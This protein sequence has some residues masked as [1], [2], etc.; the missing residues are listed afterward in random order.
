M[1]GGDLMGTV[2]LIGMMALRLAPTLRQEGAV[3]Q[4]RIL[5]A[6]GHRDGDCWGKRSAWCDYFGPVQDVTVGAAIL[7]HPD[8]LR[9]PTWWH[10]RT[11]GLFAANPFGLRHFEGAEPGTGAHTVPAGESITFRYRIYLHRGTTE[12]ADVATRFR[13]YAAIDAD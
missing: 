7:D 8:N 6:A 11:Y 4:G 10:V 2:V 1:F 12:E 9:H 13:E 5:N 3:A